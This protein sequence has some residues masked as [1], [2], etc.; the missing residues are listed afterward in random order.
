MALL[1]LPCSSGPAPQALLLLPC[2]SGPAPQALLL[3]PCS[4]GP[5]P[6]ALL[7]RP[8]SSG[9][10]PQALLLLPA[11]WSKSTERNVCPGAGDQR[12]CS[13][14]PVTRGPA[15][16]GIDGDLLRWPFVPQKSQTVEV[17]W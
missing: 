16:R 11:W 15:P 2:S 7:L 4:S 10:A 14:G 5:A 1:L 17:C 8:C 13:Q 9:P 12:S 3:R 6:Q